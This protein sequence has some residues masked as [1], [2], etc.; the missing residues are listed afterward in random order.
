MLN[1]ENGQIILEIFVIQHTSI[2]PNFFLIVLRIQKT[3]ALSVNLCDVTD[4]E[5][6][7]FN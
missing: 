4:F 7:G 5:I 2:W 3:Q 6:C 1:I